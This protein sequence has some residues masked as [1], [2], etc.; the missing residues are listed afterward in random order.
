MK[1]AVLSG[2]GGTGKTFVSVNLAVSAN[3]S[4]YIDCD[5]EEPNGH[6]FLKPDL[7][8]NKKV[9]IKIP[10]VDSALCNGCRKCVDF[11]NFNA[12]AYINHKIKVFDSICHSCGGCTLLCPFQAITE[13]EKV[14]GEIR[15]GIS[16]HV[17]VLSGILNI[18]EASG[19]PII[20]ELI[21]TSK[22][23]ET[24]TIID[25][26]PGSSCSVME[27][28]KD[29]DYCI[30]VAEPTQFGFHNL[31]MVYEL[32]TLFKKPHGIVFNKYIDGNNLYEK[33]C[34]DKNIKVLEKI[35][36]SKEIGT[37]NSEGELAA[38]KDQNYQIMFSH[39]L[40]LITKE[41][42]NETVIDP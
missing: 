26:P 41:V 16:R 15:K 5:V 22:N 8:T 42:E 25:C 32:V 10:N 33:F 29:A 6:L 7:V 21:K 40:E 24:L 17:Q 9:A 23:C 14:I 1:I 20:K 13:K 3:K 28:I 2:K 34:I 38:L 36:Y 31:E 4:I 39:I 27:S 18:G 11:C 30:L 19:V 12:L 35:P 37:L